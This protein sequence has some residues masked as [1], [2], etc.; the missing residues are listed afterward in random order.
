[1]A[2]VVYVTHSPNTSVINAVYGRGGCGKELL[3][4]GLKESLI[5]WK[6]QACRTLAFSPLLKGGMDM[7]STVAE[8][9]GEWIGSPSG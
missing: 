7:E 3:R 2:M 8:A 6:V 4:V 5:I 9:I 1:M